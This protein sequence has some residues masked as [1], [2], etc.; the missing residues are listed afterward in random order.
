[1]D[2]ANCPAPANASRHNSFIAISVLAA[3]TLF[4]S[5]FVL[6][7]SARAK[8]SAGPLLTAAN[9]NAN[10]G[11]K[12]TAAYGKLPLS[13][14]ANQGQE[15]EQVRFT[16]HGVGY[17]LFLTSDE[18][19]LALRARASSSVI[20]DPKQ[21]ADG[22]KVV[23]MKLEGANSQ[24]EINGQE[25][26]PGKL[27]Y[28]IG[29]D[30]AKWRSDVPLYAKVHYKDIY[31]GID[32][33]YYGNQRQLEYD[34]QVSPGSDPRAIKIQFEG[35][36]QV[37]VDSKDGS[38]VLVV[39]QSEVRLKRPVIYQLAEDGNRREIRGGYEV[40]GKNVKFRVGDFDKSKPLVIDPI[41]SYSTYLG[42]SSNEIGW[43]IG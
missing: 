12:V 16:A 21:A 9:I 20:K 11:H 1:M 15:N 35:T 6:L 22:Y 34:F 14:E 23:R 3:I 8:K 41:L 37:K 40:K 24:A 7:R 2:L 19:V 43:G 31:K 38:L 25:E 27:N 32:L 39:D 13:F 26:L 17:N 18:A 5:S 30:P 4:G 36:E 28:F 29:N 42:S 10:E 33:L